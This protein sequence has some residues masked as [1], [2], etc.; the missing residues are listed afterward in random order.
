[1]FSHPIF[2]SC[3]S[4]AVREDVQELQ[5]MV[6]TPDSP[7]VGSPSFMNDLSFL[8]VEE[9]LREVMSYIHSYIHTSVTTKTKI[10]ALTPFYFL[11]LFFIF[12]FVF[13]F[14]S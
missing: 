9:E 5:K 11:F 10:L 4:V 3:S 14:V 1:M 2:Q 8:E 6:S 12:V 13:V 7:V